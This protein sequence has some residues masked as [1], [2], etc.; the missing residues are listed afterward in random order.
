MADCDPHDLVSAGANEEDD[1]TP[2]HQQALKEIQNLEK[3]DIDRITSSVVSVTQSASSPYESG[4]GCWFSYL[5][6]SC[7]NPSYV[8]PHVEAAV[9]PTH[10]HVPED[11]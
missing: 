11:H 4:S 9:H 2:P 7:S 6:Q 5:R 10:H 1:H 8:I 3:E